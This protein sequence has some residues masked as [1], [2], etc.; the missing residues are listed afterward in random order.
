LL[1]SLLLPLALDVVL[2]F[3]FFIFFLLL[4]PSFCGSP[5]CP[6]LANNCRWLLS[7]AAA[8]EPRGRTRTSGGRSPK[9]ALNG[10]S[11]GWLADFQLQLCSFAARG[12]FWPEIDRLSQAFGPLFRPFEWAILVGDNRNG[13]QPK[14]GDRL[15]QKWQNGKQVCNWVNKHGKGC[16]Y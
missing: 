4:P 14:M 11:V 9:V 12:P 13:L 1:I 2:F 6:P 10:H 15:R 16:L 7:L 3:P 8:F 5:H